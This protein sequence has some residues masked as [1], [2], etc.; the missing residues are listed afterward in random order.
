MKI[1]R[2]TAGIAATNSYI[3]CSENGGCAVVDPGDDASGLKK[4]INDNGWKCTA[5]LLTH[6]HFDHAGSC[7]EFQSMGAK[8]Y[9]HA[10]D[11]QLIETDKNLA[12]LFGKKFQRF[13][14]DVVID[15]GDEIEILNEKIT[16][17]HTPGH[18]AGSVCYVVENVIF[19]GDTLFRLSVGRTDFPTGSMK[20]LNTSVKRLLALPGN[21]TVYPGHGEITNL[22]FERANNPYA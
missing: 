8:I 20:E 2:Q 10:A 14:L 19:S 3:L 15:D 12:P 21:Y 1:I 7:F 11:M 13:V 5:V 9:M 18:T 17:L 4:I 16:V 6:A 22:D